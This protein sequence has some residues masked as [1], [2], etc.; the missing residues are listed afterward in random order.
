[1]WKIRIYFPGIK[2]NSMNILWLFQLKASFAYKQEAHIL[3]NLYIPML[4][5]LTFWFMQ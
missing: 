4:I 5:S 1:M 2:I 3:E